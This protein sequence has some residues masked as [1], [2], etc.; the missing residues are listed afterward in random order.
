VNFT[1]EELCCCYNHGVH[2]LLRIVISFNDLTK[3][4][5]TSKREVT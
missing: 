3:Q 2:V 5:S 1:L 4:H